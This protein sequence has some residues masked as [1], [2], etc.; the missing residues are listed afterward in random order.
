MESFT[1]FS[2]ESFT[3]IL[4]FISSIRFHQKK[5]KNFKKNTKHKTQLELYML[6]PKLAKRAKYHIFW[7]FL[8]KKNTVSDINDKVPLFLELEFQKLEFLISSATVAL[9]S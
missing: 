4:V 9:L 7:K 5:K 8:A 6:N 3:I 1:I 2:M